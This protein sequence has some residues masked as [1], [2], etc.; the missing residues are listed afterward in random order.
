MYL[1]VLVMKGG[2]I[3]LE[4]IFVVVD[5]TSWPVLHHSFHCEKLFILQLVLQVSKAVMQ[6][7]EK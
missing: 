3:C 7:L 2:C 1:M 5:V 6:D 4:D